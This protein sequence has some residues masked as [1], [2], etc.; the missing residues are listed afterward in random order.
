MATTI[1][2]ADVPMGQVG[3][4]P[5]DRGL[6][7]CCGSSGSPWP[8]RRAGLLTAES[9]RVGGRS[10]LARR[11]VED[12]VRARRARAHGVVLGVAR[13]SR[14]SRRPV[15]RGS[16]RPGRSRSMPVDQ[17]PRRPSGSHAAPYCRADARRELPPFCWSKT[18]STVAPEPLRA[19]CLADVDGLAVELGFVE[20]GARS[21]PRAET[22]SAISTP[23]PRTHP[24]F[25]RRALFLPH[26]NGAAKSV[27]GQRF[28]E[29]AS[30][31]SRANRTHRRHVSRGSRGVAYNY[32]ALAESLDVTL[33]A[34]RRPDSVRGG[35]A[36]SAW[37]FG[38][39]ALERFGPP[40]PRLTPQ[41]FS[42]RARV[43]AGAS[44]ANL[45]AW[46][47]GGARSRY[48]GGA[49]DVANEPGTAAPILRRSRR[50]RETTPF[51]RCSARRSRTRSPGR[52]SRSETNARAKCGDGGRS[53]LIG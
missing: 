14:R 45:G 7:M 3:S 19:M 29:G 41:F 39:V 5:R 52:S 37:T 9:R 36:R 34:G 27:R 43:A 23:K 8:R 22:R 46:G 4:V 6:R 17:A 24:R 40:V 31:K 2:R 25:L 16:R 42:P 30:L 38:G 48:S 50:T 21:S 20:R 32:R 35:G 1:G 47:D 49:G 15:A 11:G 26:L 13:R 28:R 33:G 10:R 53:S 44:F 51:A 12:D 18:L